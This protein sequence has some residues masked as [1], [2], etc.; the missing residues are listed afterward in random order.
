MDD[1]KL[2]IVTVKFLLSLDRR[3][4][5]EGFFTKCLRML[6][7][8]GEGVSKKADYNMG[9]ALKIYTKKKRITFR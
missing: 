1:K 9:A 5:E 7:R 3:V 2:Y 4:G 6:T 8:G